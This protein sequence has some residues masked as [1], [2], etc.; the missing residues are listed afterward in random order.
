MEIAPLEYRPIAPEDLRQFDEQGYLIVRQALDADTVGRLIDAG[1]RLIASDLQ[2][3]RQTNSNGQYDSFRN[4]VTL[5]AAFAG[6]IDHPYILPLVVQLLGANLHLMTSHLIYKKPDPPGTPPAK[7]LPGWHR[8]YLQAM[9]DMGHAAIP[10]LELKCAYYLTDLSRPSS[11]VTMVAPGSNRLKEPMA[12]PA[13]QPDP[14]HAVEPSLQPGDCL[15]FENRTWHAGAVNLSDD[16]RKAIMIGYGYRWVMPM[17]FRRQDPA[18]IDT[19]TPLQRYLAG[20]SLNEDDNFHPD[21]GVNPLWSWAES[22]D[23]PTVRHPS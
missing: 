9:R 19:L 13:G 12:I 10:R 18:F 23:I 5:D 4:C 1:D 7:R 20:E 21:G 16:I 8:D 11:G 2:T 6:L 15:I 3:N 14:D 22:H 17:D